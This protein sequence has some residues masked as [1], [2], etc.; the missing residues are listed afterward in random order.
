MV[1]A[2]GYEHL[3]RHGLRHT[4]LRWFADAGVSVH[5]LQKIGDL[6]TMGG[7]ATTGWFIWQWRKAGAGPAT[8]TPEDHAAAAPVELAPAVSIVTDPAQLALMWPAL[9]LGSPERGWPNITAA[10]YTE[11][12]MARCGGSRGGRLDHDGASK[13]SMKNSLAVLVRVMEQAVR[14][15]P[16]ETNPARV[17]GWQKLYQQIED[18]L[19]DPRSLALPNWSGLVTLAD[20]LVERSADRYQGWGDVVIFAAG[21]ASRIGE[22]SGCRVGDIDTETWT[23]QVRRQ[24]PLPGGMADKG[25][26]GQPCT[27]GP[28]DRGGSAFGGQAS[29]CCQA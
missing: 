16:R 14:D 23:W 22:V 18:E 1:S 29:R 2:L 19:D 5:R 11:A 3:R 17:R 6:M 26:E 28:V 4:G 21:T 24:T 9:G 12:G 25:D 13:S 15:G 27:L 20:A 8:P 7:I 10:A